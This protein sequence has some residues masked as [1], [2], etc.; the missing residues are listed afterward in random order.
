MNLPYVRGVAI[1]ICEVRDD[2]SK[3]LKTIKT[4]NIPLKIG[5]YNNDLMFDL[6]G[7]I[8]VQNIQL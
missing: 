5:T 2:K 8:S 3:Q 1:H 7:Q 6:P 4:I